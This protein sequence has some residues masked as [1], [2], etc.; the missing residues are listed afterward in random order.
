PNTS[1]SKAALLPDPETSLHIIFGSRTG[2]SKAAAELAYAYSGHL[3]LENQLHNMQNM[4]LEDLAFMKNMLIVVSTHGEGDPPAVAESFYNYLHDPEL[5]L[6]DKSHFSVLALGDSSYIDYC[7][8]G[9]DIRNRLLQL[10]SNEISPLVECDI[11]YEEN[12]KQWVRDAVEAF[13]KWLPAVNKKSDKEFAFEINKIDASDAQLYYARLLDKKML[14]A[15][16]YQKR[17]LHLALSVENFKSSF[18]PGDSFGIYAHNSRLLVDKLLKKLRFDGTTAVQSGKTT[19]L[20]KEALIQDVE[21]TLVTPLVVEK[22]AR[23]TS[24]AALGKLLQNEAALTSYCANHDMLDLVTDFPGKLRPQDFIDLLRVLKPRLYSVANSPLAY[25]GE[26]H[27]TVGLMEYPLN[28]RLHSG[29]CSTFIADRVDVGDSIPISLEANEKFRLPDDNN[30]PI[31]MIATGTGV[32]PFRAFLQTRDHQKAKGSNWLFFGD[33]HADSDFLYREEFEHYF[34][35]GLLTR[36]STVFS[37]D[38]PE[39]KYVQQLLLEN[40]KELFEWIQDREA[41]VYL[42]GNKRTMGKDV[43]QTLEQI[44]EKEA[45]LSS[46]EAAAYIEQLK[47]QNRL[48][49][50]LY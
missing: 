38:T 32:A 44:V 30:R 28:E 5:R 17:T 25:P 26:V 8:T 40:S 13:V 31:I 45:D 18:Q 16:G 39:K 2:N 14:T 34:K 4:A 19:K 37:R 11:D 50:D 12:A 6:M 10:G 27:F 3:G 42:C 49:M 15:A 21:I 1:E 20:L 48:Q 24:H 29:V 36:L 46:A 41:V 47:Q 7:K 9:H 33:R 35:S 23:A 43:K 22:Y